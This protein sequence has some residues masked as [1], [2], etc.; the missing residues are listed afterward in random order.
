[1]ANG[2]T[3]YFDAGRLL[4]GLD[5]PGVNLDAVAVSQRKNVDAITKSGELALDGARAIAK[6]QSEMV[7]ESTEEFSEAVRALVAA[8][9]FETAA[10]A[11]AELAKSNYQKTL[12]NLWEL[13]ELATKANS[14]TLGVINKRVAA[15]LDEVKTIVSR[16]TSTS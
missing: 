15:G 1:M 16:P 5:V 14:K 12:A 9:S 2:S 4:E 3:A 6:R 8:G 11:M 13:G 10:V 7:S